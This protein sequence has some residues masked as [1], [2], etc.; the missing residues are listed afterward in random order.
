[1]FFIWGAINSSAIFF[2]PI[3]KTFG[4]TRAK[5]SVALSIGWITGG[6]ASPL[7]GWIADRVNPKRMMIVG[8]TVTG[9]AWLALSRA[10]GFGEFF[11]INGLFGI[12]V[13]A[14]TVIPI[15]IVIASWFEKR[16]GLAMGIAF[17]GATLGGAVMTIVANY[18]IA[19]GGWRVGYMTLGL[20]ILLIVVPLIVFFV[21]TR[22]SA[23]I[24]THASAAREAGSTEVFELQ[25]LEIS[26]ATKTRSF[27]LIST[28]QLLTGFSIGMAQHYVA[29]LNGIGYTATFAATVI[30]LYLVVTTVGTLLGGP[31]AD[32][33]GARPALLATYLLSALGMFGMLTASHPAAL[34][35][36]IL[37]GGFAAG[38]LGVQ[39][40]LLMIESLG[41]KR[42]GSVMGITSVFYTLGA[43]A[44]PV[45]IG[46]IFDLTGSYSFAITSFVLMLLGCSLAMV[47]CR[48]LDEEQRQFAPPE[49]ASPVASSIAV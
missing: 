34:A 9:L 24:D 13:G 1:M 11:A 21:R 2:V 37:A 45:I 31:L 7:I 48:S 41:L 49:P 33:F 10:T 27:W 40:P 20:P 46:R 12:C 39:M 19:H 44:S 32:R 3:L 36:N 42:F 4:W 15:S 23:E 25:G 29:Y 6:A 28:A 8:A 17:A 22:T 16:R 35:L 26:Q 18:A 30:S 38:A 47:F 43:A 14:S 5:L